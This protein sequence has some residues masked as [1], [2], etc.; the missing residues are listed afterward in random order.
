MNTC[1][2]PASL[3]RS[4]AAR[5]LI[6]AMATLPALMVLTSSAT[7]QTYTWNGT[8]VGNGTYNWAAGTNWS[9]V[10]VSGINSV[11]SYTGN[12]SDSAVI[13]SNN[14]VATPPFQLNQLSFTTGN[15]T[16]AAPTLTLQGSQ[17]EF[18]TNGSAVA[19]TLIFNTTGT[20]RPTIDIQNNLVLTNNLTAN[21]TSIG[22]LSGVISGGGNLAKI[23]N[24]VLTLA[25]NNTYT[26]ATTIGGTAGGIVV[27]ANNALGSTAGTT[28]VGAG[29]SLGLSGG[30]NY[31]TAETILGS[32]TGTATAVGAFAAAQR[33]MVQSV[34]GNNTFAG[35]IQINATG[36]T[37]FGTQDGAQ[38]NLSGPITI[39]SGVKGV[40]I[41]FRSG[42]TNGD[43]ITLSNT[44][45]SWD[46]DTQLFSGNAGT[47]SGVRLGADNALSTLS[48]V[49][50]TGSTGSG[51][52][53][54]LAGFNQEI[55]GLAN[56]QG[57][58]NTL[59]VINSDSSK[60][61]ILTLNTAG[62]RNSGGA[63]IL[64]GAGKIQVVKTGNFDQIL[65]GVNTYTGGTRIDQGSLTLGNATNTLANTGA[66]N[67]NGGTLALGT[68]N[69]TVGAVTLTSGSITGTGNA[70]NGIL[71]GTGSNFDVRSG[72]VSAA[73]AGSVGLTKTT[74]GT[75]TLSG[76]NT[77]SGSTTVSEGVLSVG[78]SANLGGASSAL[79]LDG[80]TLQVTGTTLTSFSGR[81][82]TFTAGK[83]VSLDINNAANA[84][85][86]GQVLN[87]TSG[88]LTKLGAGTAILN[89][90]NTYTGVTSITAGRL[91]IGDGTDNGSIAASSAVTNN[92][93]LV[94]NVGSGNRTFSNDI[95][96]SGGIT[97]SG[98]GTITLSGTNT[99]N[100][101]TTVSSGTLRA[102]ST[103]AFGVGSAVSLG[104]VAGAT[105]DLNGNNV[106][107]GRLNGG[108]ATAG[109]VAFGTA[110]LTITNASGSYGGNLTGSG[111]LRLTGGS[112]TLGKASALYTGN[113]T[114]S[115]GA[116]L[117]SQSNTSNVLGPNTAGTQ[118]V[119]VE[120]GATFNHNN[121]DNSAQQLQNFVIN[122]TGAGGRVAAFEATGMGYGNAAIRGL[123]VATDSS[124]FVN[125]WSAAGAGGQRGL[126][127]Q[128]P[129]A[130]SGNLTIT[131]GLNSG[132]VTL[133]AGTGSVAGYSAFTG[134][135]NVRSISSNATNAGGLI[136]NSATALGTTANIDLGNNTYFTVGASQTIGGLS[137]NASD[138]IAARVNLGANTLTIGS[139]NNLNS[140]FAGV[141]SGTGGLTKAGTGTLILSGNSS[142]SGNTSVTSGILNIQNA[143]ALG[144]TSGVTAVAVGATLQL[145]GGTSYAPE[146][147][148]LNTG[149][150]GSAVLQ[151]VS[152]N[153]T[154]NGIV[155]VTGSFTN[156][157]VTR[158]SSD[159]DTL[160]L[161]G[162]VNL[163]TVN[164]NAVSQF[165]LQGDGSIDVTGKISGIGAVTSGATGTG[166]R[167][168]S[169]SANDYTGNTGVNGGTLQAGVD[170]AIPYG[171]GKGNMTFSG[172]G[173]FDLN[174]FDVNVNG[175][176]ATS[177][178]VSVVNNATGTNKT[179]TVGNNDVTA[180]FAGVI[181][182]NTSGTGT[183]ALT[184]TGTGALTLS[185]NNTY[186]GGTTVNG[187]SLFINSTSG[188]GTGSITVNSGVLSVN[189]SIG[190]AIT[191]SGGTLSGNAT[192]SVDLALNSTASVISPGN[193]PGIS[194]FTT[195][196]NWTAYTYD[197]E[198]ND[199]T[200][201]T[202][203]TDFDN[204]SITTGGM[205]LTG[206]TSYVLNVISLMG[207]NTSGI[208]PNFGESSVS[209]SII[210]TQAGITAFDAGKWTINSTAFAALNGSTGTF[211]LVLTNADKDLSLVYTPVPEPSAYAA[212]V[213]FGALGFVAYRRRKTS[214]R[215]A[216]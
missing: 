115:S 1:S 152:G 151:N 81:T 165:V 179:L 10:P 59:K 160:T 80:G 50:S 147:L 97:Q 154:W 56:F 196:Q 188:A 116:V 177:T 155:N 29:T 9:A 23:G 40:T 197:W 214:Q 26:G 109:T 118:V 98:T 100:G 7:A 113:V 95:S 76:N 11:L 65:N 82:V 190:N 49:Y 119:T 75:V 207:D 206:G 42:A 104:T 37:R 69:D 90:T 34:S 25:G 16:G 140:S 126:A 146:T 39:S 74:V 53:L 211:S 203:G 31:S 61:S 169:N 144:S 150:T 138:T 192:L 162:D 135:V 167:K 73:L 158:V 161:A 198:I 6:A 51:T 62:N 156:S 121:A 171:A 54:D 176:S 163:G 180:S 93:T 133:S 43:F 153:N 64:D 149:N 58:A 19:P 89:Q 213:G 71:T 127:I 36:V 96:G 8:S 88:G 173:V 134:N 14:D 77:Y 110:N 142:F 143:N 33:G 2:H 87:Q 172:T 125:S 209:W 185:G 85:T 124:M 48:V 166:I 191:L 216:A 32:G 208:V 201:T 107:I 159:S 45:N 164:A 22:R 183:V 102:G 199:F 178:T 30:I 200:G 112:Q 15:T 86:V 57:S 212:L 17:L 141:I 187:G 194:E 70:T 28:T 136:S 193:S 128:G 205:N 91:Q 101:T 175:L 184:K 129:L 83:T 182:D 68:N 46:G 47:G 66:V 106:S 44:G 137:S 13:V 132:F 103:Q 5:R 215:K 210:S 122:G 27:T 3:P 130:G 41:L 114:I 12:L 148:R 123:A 84:F 21:A 18:V 204:I 120:S 78:T 181:A 186:S 63:T 111:S 157:H 105:L 139:T 72:S 189:A 94:F 4:A 35:A 92:G 117:V 195:T 145:Q 174:G 108:N 202:A 60:V 67:V 52:T 168:L 38:L 99:Y 131:S 55:R 79:S 24:G 170:N 20:V